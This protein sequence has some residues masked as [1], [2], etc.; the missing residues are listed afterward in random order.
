MDIKVDSLFGIENLNDYKI[1]FALYDGSDHPLDVFVR[2]RV[3]WKGWNSWRSEKINRFTRKY[4]FSMIRYHQHDKWLFGGIFEVKARHKAS[5]T[6]ELLE[7]GQE[8]IGRLVIHCKSPGLNNTPYLETHYDK[9][10]VSQIF[11]KPYSGEYFSGYENIDHDFHIIETIFK[12]TKKD[13]KAALENV[14]G[15]YLI[16]D[17]F[18]G[19]MYVGSAYGESGIWSRW[20]Q[21]IDTG[22][23]WNDELTQIIDKE[24]FEYA[25]KNFKFSLL[26]YRSM[27][28]DD[29]VIIDREQY[30]KN[31]LLSGKY[32]YNKN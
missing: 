7:N 28:T 27:K 23:G 12:T 32:G 15:V 22:H 21:Y 24:G 9:L 30:W 16:V 25:R 13:W 20:G 11:D 6:V 3:E 8:Y 31:V 19:K 18:N 29:Q 10:I 26:E 14:K 2:S 4:I 17:K 1:H 5:Y